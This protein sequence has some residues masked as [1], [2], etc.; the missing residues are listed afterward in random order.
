MNYK[1]GRAD[2]I[3][4]ILIDLHTGQWFGWSDPANKVYANLIIHPKIWD[5][6]YKGNIHEDGL[7]D[8]PYSKPTEKSLTDALAQQQ[9]DFDALQYQ[10]D[11]RYPS[12]GDQLDMQYWDQVNGTTTWKDA[13]AK[14]KADN[15][16]K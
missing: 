1:T 12:I 2:H 16:K 10:R 15:P 13:V 8:N 4:D 7:I 9:S 6:S 3:E 14:V 5:E 11:R